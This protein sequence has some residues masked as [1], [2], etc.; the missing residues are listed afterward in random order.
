MFLLFLGKLG[1]ELL[2]ELSDLNFVFLLKLLF[3]LSDLG[4]N[5]KLACLLCDLPFHCF[6]LTL[7]FRVLFL[8]NLLKVYLKLIVDLPSFRFKLAFALS[9]KSFKL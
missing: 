3:V 1:V 9:S 4:F 7:I 2:A 6:E 8:L 5:I